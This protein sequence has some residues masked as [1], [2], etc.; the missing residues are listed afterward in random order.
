M[1]TAILQNKPIAKDI[2]DLRVSFAPETPPAPGQFCHIVC[3]DGHL[4]R[5]P[6]SLCGSDGEVARMVYAVRG[7]GTRWLST[8]RV[9]QRLDL[10]GPLGRGF[11][12]DDRPTLLVG[13]GIG[14]PPM[15]F[16]ADRLEGRSHAILGFRNAE[17]VCLTEAFASFDLLTDDGSAGEKGYP[18]EVLREHL[19]GGPWERVLSCGPLPMLKAV[20]A[21]C[22]EAHIP[23]QV[24]LEE[25]M[26]CG[27]GACLVCACAAGGTMKRVCKDGPVF[28]AA[29]VNWDA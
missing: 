13:G 16:C 10:L 21:V 4:L 26:A 15:A 25:R 3:G 14:V 18:H 19:Q 17:A 22:A 2:Y 1:Q 7:D 23:C 5:R 6:I 11:T 27:I 20:A 29:E 9:G 24:S 12:L 28:D 8:R